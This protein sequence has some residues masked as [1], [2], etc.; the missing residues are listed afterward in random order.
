MCHRPAKVVDTEHIIYTLSPAVLNEYRNVLLRPKLTRLHKL[1]AAAIEDLLEELT[2][3]AIWREPT[4]T[5][6]ALDPGDNHLWALLATYPG[7]TLITGDKLLLERPPSASSLISPA[8][9]ISGFVPPSCTQNHI[10]PGV[11]IHEAPRPQLERLNTCGQDCSTHTGTPS[12]T[13]CRPTQPSSKPQATNNPLYFKR[14]WSSFRPN[15][16]LPVT[17][18][19]GVTGLFGALL[20]APRR[21]AERRR[22]RYT[23]ERCNEQWSEYLRQDLLNAHRQHINHLMQSHATGQ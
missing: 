6:Q 4:A 12:I 7:S 22:M 19:C 20:P 1:D 18:L 8:S 2:C 16:P 15:F 9:Y 23:A 10:T 14:P 5:A 13:S 17:P 3:N 11:S 21:G